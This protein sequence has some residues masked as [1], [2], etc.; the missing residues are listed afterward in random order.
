[1]KAPDD[2]PGFFIVDR[3]A[4]QLLLS[5]NLS[6]LAGLIDLGSS[7]HGTVDKL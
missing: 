2:F 1:M 6:L 3:H 7:V 5:S 4:C